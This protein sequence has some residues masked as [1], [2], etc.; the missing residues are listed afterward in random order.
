MDISG[1]YKMLLIY[2]LNFNMLQHPLGNYKSDFGGRIF[3]MA[4]IML[5][6]CK[7]IIVEIY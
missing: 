5:D 7:N 4:L 3:M 2:S 1:L 6:F